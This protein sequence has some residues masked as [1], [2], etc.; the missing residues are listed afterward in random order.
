MTYRQ[1][2]QSCPHKRQTTSGSNQY[3][4]QVQCLDCNGHSAIWWLD[5]VQ[6]EMLRDMLIPERSRIIEAVDLAPEPVPTPPPPPSRADRLRAEV[7][8]LRKLL[9]V[10]HERLKILELE[11]IQNEEMI[12]D[13]IAK[14]WEK[15]ETKADSERPW[16]RG[17]SSRVSRP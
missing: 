2:Q 12:A 1:P 3:R 7:M 13:L 5:V 17:N 15:P 8:G 16:G 10:A 4:R 14:D 6:K 11:K 9:E